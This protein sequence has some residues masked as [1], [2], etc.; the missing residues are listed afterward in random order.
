M[1]LWE[2]DIVRFSFFAPLCEQIYAFFFCAH[3]ELGRSRGALR[4]FSVS[5]EI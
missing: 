2:A 1:F 3:S 5:P 4:V